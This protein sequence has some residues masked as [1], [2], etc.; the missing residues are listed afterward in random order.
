MN[1]IDMSTVI[2]SFTISNAICMAVVARLWVRNRAHFAGLGFWL[3][4]FILLLVGIVLI[5]LRGSVPDLLSMVVSNTLLLLGTLLLYIGLERFVGN[6][7]SQLHNAVLLV[8]FILVQTYFTVIEPNLAV[9]TINFSLGALALF[10]Q[11]A[12]LMLRRANTE[13]SPTT[14]T[15]GITLAAFSVISAVRIPALLIVP[16]GNDFFN[17][18]I[19]ETVVILTYQMLFIA[20]TFDLSVLINRRLLSNLERELLQRQGIEE[21]LTESKEKFARAFHASPDAILISRL[22]D[23]RLI[24]VNE[25]FSR[26]TEYSH[27]EALS[28]SSISLNLWANPEDRDRCVAAL[29]AHHRIHD[30]E[31]DFRAK[32]GRIRNGLYSGEIIYLD[33]EAHVLAVVRDITEQKRAEE[34]LRESEDRYRQLFEAESDPILLI[35]NEGGRILEAN[36]AAASLY[37]Y[38]REELLTKR[39]TDLSAE[40]EETQRVTRST[41]I[42]VEN[43]VTIPLRLHRKKNGTVFPVEITGRFFTWRGR[44]VHIAAIRDI[45]ERR[46]AEEIVAIR[47]RLWEYAATHS[48]DELMQQ[49][50]DE[51][52]ELT[53]SPI[54]F[55][56][57]IED[58][59]D[60]VSR[61][62]WSIHTLQELCQ[63]EDIWLH[64][65][66]SEAGV[67]A[68]CVYQRKPI[69][70]NSYIA[71][72]HRKGLPDGHPEIVRELLVPTVRNDRVVSVLGIGNKPSDYSEQDV[73]LVDY[74]A[75]I[76]YS[77]VEYKRTEEALRR[78]NEELEARNA[79]LDAF[80]HMVAHG[81]KGPLSAIIGFTYV[82]E[83]SE[84]PPSEEEIPQII[85]TIKQ[86]GLKVDTIIEE[87]MVLAGLRK[88]D[89]NMKPLDM[90]RILADT[91]ER[92]AY[93]IEQSGA[94]ITCPTDWPAAMGYGPWVEEVWVNYISNAIKYGGYPPQV[95]LGASH[96]DEA[97][98]FW[99]R[100]NGKGLSAEEQARLFEPFERLG[101]TRLSGHG[102][103]LSI[104]RQIVE[105]MGG[106]VSVASTGMSGEGSTFSFTL[107][108]A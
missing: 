32:S 74:T 73:E 42:V 39:N 87:L 18:T 79:E 80:G 38:S 27:E 67:W 81:L 76:I 46:Q 6:Q 64:H 26:L 100:D 23:G 78:A 98:R 33:N 94:A 36:G 108:A 88:A 95:E 102:L 43:V 72:P 19:F 45:T 48:V 2:L 34:A 17:S 92:M 22:S 50:L 40:P 75:G 49:A 107:P 47:L 5:A 97:V 8:I 58:D 60:T 12:W 30:M 96:E 105:R 104:V 56:H 90:P 44:P 93:Q 3:A 103:G 61:Q 84:S 41:P 1:L 7:S 65:N 99:V 66:I 83:S 52:G 85:R 10:A 37:G 25:A 68:D 82:L 4:D 31:Y 21:A 54:G 63:T 59:Q 51:I 29:Q 89:L 77:I 71:L 101:Q 9:R 35:E 11:A 69:I 70:H 24:E 106:Q 55:Y 14:R 53:S 91:L 28:G 13:V 16:P 57:I 20:L 62:A 15:V 86:L